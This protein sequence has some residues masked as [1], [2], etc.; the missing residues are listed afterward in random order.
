[1]SG[2]GNPQD[3]IEGASE[4]SSTEL[5]IFGGLHVWISLRLGLVFTPISF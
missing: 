3:D 1:M 2:N 4:T 5:K